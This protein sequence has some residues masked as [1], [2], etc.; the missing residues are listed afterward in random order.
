MPTKP[1]RHNTP[2]QNPISHSSQHSVVLN[3]SIKKIS[4]YPKILPSPIV[5]LL[6]N[7]FYENTFKASYSGFY[8][9]FLLLSIFFT[10]R[11]ELVESEYFVHLPLQ[12]L[13]ILWIV[14]EG[15][16]NMKM[17]IA[18]VEGIFHWNCVL[19]SCSRQ[20]ARQVVRKRMQIEMTHQPSQINHPGSKEGF[21]RILKEAT[22]RR[23]QYPCRG[24]FMRPVFRGKQ[25]CLE[26]EQCISLICNSIMEFC[27]YIGQ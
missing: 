22:P 2:N 9:D 10:W 12:S 25:L 19:S 24:E 11:L 17:N 27:Q 16:P 15:E 23:Q 1:L 4:P 6:L 20:T 26:R 14:N 21:L 7:K 8:K 5:N 18:L 13:F 3:Y